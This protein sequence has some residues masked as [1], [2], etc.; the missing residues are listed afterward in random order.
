[1][2]SPRRWARA[3]VGTAAGHAVCTQHW[4]DPTLHTVGFLASSGSPGYDV[5]LRSSSVT[6]HCNVKVVEADFRLATVLCADISA[7]GGVCVHLL[8]DEWLWTGAA[9][10]AQGIVSGAHSW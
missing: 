3:C 2:R 9:L 5:G 1:M 8:K 7:S 4:G 6:P 10:G